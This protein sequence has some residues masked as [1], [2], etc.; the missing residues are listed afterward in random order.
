MS[1]FLNRTSNSGCNH[2][3]RKYSKAQTNLITR[4]SILCCQLTNALPVIMFASSPSERAES[5]VFSGPDGDGTGGILARDESA[6]DG[7]GKG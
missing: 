5:E 2:D 7:G 6:V 3:S 4:Q 1:P